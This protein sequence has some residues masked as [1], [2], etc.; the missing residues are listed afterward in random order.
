[1][2]GF[3][4][5]AG[6]VYHILNFGEVHGRFDQLEFPSLPGGLAWDTSEL[7]LQGSLSVR[8]VPETSS[9][10]LFAIGFII[11]AMVSNKTVTNPF[12]AEAM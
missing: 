9:C 12:S 8:S 7:Y 6:D 1:V 11:C 5:A 3:V 4:P 10:M 2:N